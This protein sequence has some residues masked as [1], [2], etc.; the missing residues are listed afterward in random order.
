VI[1]DRLAQQLVDS[2]LDPAE[3]RAK[4]ALYESALAGCASLGGAT[5][6]YAWWVPGRLEVFGKHTDYA[7]GRSLIA[8]VPRGFAFVAARG[9]GE[10]IHL[11]DTR[12]GERLTLGT[13]TVRLTGWRHYVEIVVSRL[14]RNFPGSRRGAI[15]AVKS[16]LPRASGM[17][18]SS[19]L[20]VGVA[21]ALARLWDLR[22]RDEWGRNFK[23]DE[24]LATYFACIENGLTFGTLAGDAG[25]GTHGGSED[26][27]AMLLGRPGHVSAYSF[28]P[29]RHLADARVPD[30]W[31]FVIV[32]SGVR[33]EKTGSARDAYNR[34]SEG[35]AMLLELWNGEGPHSE[36]LARA[37]SREAAPDRLRDLIRRKGVPGW[38][39]DAL[40]RRLAHFQMED[41]LVLE[42]LSAF[43]NGDVDVLGALS[44]SSQQGA[45]NLLG[46]QVPE[47]I[48]LV[49]SA[50]V[51]GAFAA[52]SFGAGFGGSVWALVERERADSFAALW[53]ADYAAHY[54][55]SG[56]VCFVARPGPPLT[57]LAR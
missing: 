3:M 22:A 38:P 40:E 20:V 43:E 28:V 9:T 36:S 31:R 12:T 16:D 11:L 46:N 15:I 25:V 17:S 42:A 54:P 55:A 44:E 10:D 48:E 47:T 6:D 52:C 27:A 35:A 2:G 29:M 56:P 50:R 18:S 37:L 34:L 32:S 33:A 5:P 24:S 30:G 19:A 49:H 1:P 45:E 4:T 53:L 13:E 23:D 57:E 7:G 26:H 8:A 51:S 41:A 39:A 21:T 14:A